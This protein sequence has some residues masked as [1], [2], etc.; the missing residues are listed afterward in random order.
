VLPSSDLTLG[1]EILRLGP[2][3]IPRLQPIHQL[4][5]AGLD[6]HRLGFREIWLVVLLGDLMLCA[7][8]STVSVSQPFERDVAS[9]RSQ[10]HSAFKEPSYLHKPFFRLGIV[11]NPMEYT[12]L[13]LGVENLEVCTL[14]LRGNEFV[15]RL[16]GCQEC[17]AVLRGD[18][19]GDV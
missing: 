10:N 6:E 11:L 9:T 4:E 16:Q 3:P 1:T 13:I 18:V 12:W 19:H 14:R 7:A 2:C 5:F 15:Y 8:N 17:F